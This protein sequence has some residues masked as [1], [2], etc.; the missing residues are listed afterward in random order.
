[1]GGCIS[2]LCGCLCEAEE[3]MLLTD[4][5]TEN[6]AVQHGC[7]GALSLAILATCSRNVV[8]G[9]YDE[10]G[11]LST[12]NTISLHSRNSNSRSVSTTGERD[13][14][15]A[16]ALCQCIPG[17]QG[18]SPLSQGDSPLIYAM[19]PVSVVYSAGLSQEKAK[20]ATHT[21]TQALSMSK[22]ENET[23]SSLSQ[24]S[25]YSANTPIVAEEYPEE[26]VSF[27][28]D[29]NTTVQTVQTD[30][31]VCAESPRSVGSLSH[32]LESSSHSHS[33]S[34]PGNDKRKKKSTRSRKQKQPAKDTRDTDAASTAAE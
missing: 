27:D 15:S 22:P 28:C 11:E 7:K 34:L 19:R 24:E 30:P 33:H 5:E 23:I 32:L 16:L 17:T 2:L 25:L 3:S 10:F 9:E 6:K 29:D 4:F 8:D 18:L 20:S 21:H 1:M 12:L 14:I 13:V 31:T 26:W